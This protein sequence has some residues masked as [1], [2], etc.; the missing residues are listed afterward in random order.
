MSVKT[1]K[2]TENKQLTEHFKLSEMHCH[3]K[4][5][6]STTKIDIEVV[7]IAEKMRCALGVPIT[8]ESGYRCP[9]HNKAVGGANGSGHTHGTALDLTTAKVSRDRLSVL[10]ELCGATRIGVYPT[11]NKEK[12]AHIGVGPKCHWD[13]TGNYLPTSHSFLNGEW[14]K[15][16]DCVT[17]KSNKKYIRWMQGWLFALGYYN[18]KIDGSWGANTQRAVNAF[19]K[20]NGW[21]SAEFLKTKAINTLCKTN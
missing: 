11:P 8:I 18:G 9:A 17:P 4:G 16:T 15:P 10:A 14:A 13:G 21:K 19:R 1:Y 2:K 12:M 6:C 3:G 20:A 5:C 7:K